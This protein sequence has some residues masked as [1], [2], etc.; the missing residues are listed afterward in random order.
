[1]LVTV[2]A[3]GS[4]GNSTLIQT[5]KLNVL[6][7]A[8]TNLKYLNEKLSELN[9]S[10]EDINYIFFTH[11]HKDHIGALN[12]IVKK[13]HPTLCMG[14]K[15]FMELP[16]LKDYEDI[17]ILIDEFDLEDLHI[18]MIK[19][20][21]D[22]TESIGYIFSSNASSL[23]YITD[24]GYI[25]NKYFEKLSN[26]SMYILESNHDVEMLMH[27]KYPAWLKQRV[28]SD[29]G[30]LSNESSSFYLTKFIGRNTKYVVLAHL[31]QEN[32]TEDIAYNTL[33]NKLN[34]YNIEFN[35][36]YIA[37]QDNKTENFII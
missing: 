8:G 4:K 36:I 17:I 10:L 1:M 31:S 37:K 16:Y 7:D 21:H 5:E 24:T 32:N 29:K 28:L 6:I 13:Y 27:G 26:K 2:L 30:H 11:T 12:T 20:S 23:V 34:E 35:N 33:K 18:D 9:L 14:Q 15:M 25:N 22:V 3:S 19:T